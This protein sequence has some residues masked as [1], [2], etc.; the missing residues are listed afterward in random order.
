MLQVVD[1]L[2]AVNEEYH[3]APVRN[4]VASH[5]SSHIIVA[6][7]AYNEERFIGSVVLQCLQYTDDVVVLDDGSTDAT[8][9][10]AEQAGAVVLRHMVNRGKSE[11]VNTALAWARQKHADALVFIDGDGQHRPSELE[12]VLGPV[13][14]GEADMVVGSRFLGVKSHIPA[15]RKVGQHAFTTVTNIAS[16]DYS[17]PCSSGRCCVGRHQV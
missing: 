11:A 15:Y 9:L 13:L 12:T 16:T 10:I 8:A 2:T 1:F 14:N 7:P 4:Q 5:D 3:E 6:I 17:P